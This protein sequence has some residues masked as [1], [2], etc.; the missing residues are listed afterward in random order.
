MTP[1]TD[2]RSDQDRIRA[3][4]KEADI[5]VVVPAYNSAQTLPATIDSLLRQTHDNFRVLV[6]DDGSTEPIL[7]V[8]VPDRRILSYRSTTNAGYAAATNTALDMISSRW[9]VFVDSDDT[10]DP[11][12]LEMLTSVGDQEQ[13]DVVVPALRIV[14][15]D[16]RSKPSPFVFPGS[17]QSGRD[18]LQLFIDGRILFNQHLLFRPTTVRAVN[19]TYSDM[20]FVLR[21]LAQ[22][23][24]VSF[25]NEFLYNR[26]IHQDSVT[27]RLRE[28][29]W[30]LAATVDEV[31]PTLFEVFDDLRAQKAL[32]RV[33]WMQYQYM[34]SA[35]GG[36]TDAPV[37]RSDVYA[38]CRKRVRFFDVVDAVRSRHLGKALSL[39]IGRLSP[40]LHRILY[41]MR[42][43]YKTV[44]PR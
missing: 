16:G 23:H 18:A 9:V 38:W 30:D 3:S 2:R 36:D 26:L 21:T 13:A 32:R 6:V 25:V 20:G 44:A 8:L 5:T 15:P 37:L 35:A 33:R 29:V 43:K 41:R 28:T 17:P 40:P 10:L 22:A 19:N 34:L 12:C 7:D 14:M 24:R 39:G 27:G 1:L 4:T 31:R 42:E 11:N